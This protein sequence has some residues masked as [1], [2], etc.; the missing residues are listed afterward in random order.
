MSLQPEQLV[1]Q[2]Q[3]N[4]HQPPDQPTEVAARPQRF[5]GIDGL[6]AIAAIAVLVY[7]TTVHYNVRSLEFASWSWID[8]LGNFGVSTFFLISGVLLY[9]PF[10]LAHLRSEARPSR[11]SFWIR[12]FFRIFPAYWVAL[13]AVFLW[14]FA[15]LKSIGDFFTTYLLLQNYRWGMQLFGIGVEWTL[16][17]EVSF[18]LALPFLAIALSSLSR[19]DADP[20]AKVIGHLKGLA[21]MYGAAMLIRI[22]SLWVVNAHPKL[23]RGT[24]F[25]LA[26]VSAWLVGYLDWFALGMLLA[27]ASAWLA[28]GGRLPWLVDWF[29]KRPWA[30]WLV[31]LE[32]YWVALQLHLPASVFDRV[33][34][35]QSFGIAFTYGIVALFLLIPA[36]FG[37]PHQGLIRKML[38]SR[39]MHGLGSISFGIYLWH[40]LIVKHVEGWSKS[41]HVSLNLFVWLALVLSITL[42]VAT[43]SYHLVEKPLIKV[44]HRLSKRMKSPAGVAA[45]VAKPVVPPE[46]HA[47]RWSFVEFLALCGIAIAQ[48]LLD[49]LGKNAGLFVTNNVSVVEAVLLTAVVVLV[50]PAVLFIAEAVVVALLPRSRRTVHRL[51]CG[52]TLGVVA[53]E[54]VKH[55][56]SWDSG[57]LIAVAIGVGIAGAYAIGRFGV[58]RQF[59]RFLGYAPILFVVLFLGF[60]PVTD[61]VFSGQK[62]GAVSDRIKHPKRIIYIV[63]DEFPLTSL[64]DGTGHVDREL[65]P[66]FAALADTSNWY[67]NV[68]TVAPYTTLAVP[69]LLTGNFPPRPTAL[70][71]RIDYPNNLFTLLSKDY[72]V[73]AHEV[74]TRLCPPTLCRAKQSGSLVDLTRQSAS[75]WQ[76][77]ASPKRTSFSFN[78]DE[79][80]LQALGTSRRFIQSLKKSTDRQLDFVHIEMPHQPWHYIQTLQDTQATGAIPGAK[81]LEFSDP[82]SAAHAMRR[83]LL[84]VQAVDTLLGRIIDKLKKVGAFDNSMVVVTAD[85]GIAF[86]N[87]EPLRS[88]SYKNYPNILWTPLFVKLPGQSVGKVDDRPAMS[89]DVVP[90]IADVIG[91]KIPWKVDGRSLLGTPRQEF[92]RPL[93]QWGQNAIELDRFLKAP[94]GHKFLEFDGAKGFAQVIHTRAVPPAGDPAT[95]IYRMSP[96]SQLVGQDAASYVHTDSSKVIANIS[97]RDAL[98]NVNPTATDVSWVYGEGFLNKTDGA[99]DIAIALNGKIVA[100]AASRMFAGTTDAYFLYL[101]PPSLVSSGDNHPTIYLIKGTAAKPA[102]DP[103]AFAAGSSGP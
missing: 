80:A 33:T 65:F 84:Q 78:E 42:I 96:E 100:T 92:K 11:G 14:N 64:L 62:S 29:I 49:L 5:S 38:S 68:S 93:Y 6:R 51:L 67:R 72:A 89:I 46:P 63:F 12:R 71:S 37:D 1:P 21:I 101:I 57:A 44:S 69:A 55:Q 19:S 43:L 74:V 85:H 75:L 30:C 8:R 98:A 70:P 24:W 22:W 87:K 18:Y 3:G 13:T 16:V 102:L 23:K 17:I 66:N 103:I 81:Y 99:Y 90:T 61:V 79:G 45:R 25:P 40:L 88:V 60:S 94:K 2:V 31:A 82:N 9:R 97:G 91:A 76:E 95:R 7:H 39:V 26:Q 10:V 56:T 47:A 48:P 28:T 52:L 54:A 15:H 59:L 36:V 73:N 20:R 4:D 53:L 35:V 83:H 86:Q 32:T 34:R 58:V 27:V 41:N 50:P 77:F